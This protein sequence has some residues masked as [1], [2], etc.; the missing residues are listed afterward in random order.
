MVLLGSLLLAVAVLSLRL[1]I[2]SH[3]LTA[4]NESKKDRFAKLVQKLNY[5]L[6]IPIGLI[7]LIAGCVWWNLLKD[8]FIP[9][10]VTLI[11]A[12]ITMLVQSKSAI[13]SGDKAIRFGR[14]IRVLSWVLAVAII[15]G[16]GFLIFLAI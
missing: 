1:M 12:S 6:I 8:N 2:Q 10:G 7:M 3:I 4:T 5:V 13:V 9:V 15:I 14:Y 11:I 16:F